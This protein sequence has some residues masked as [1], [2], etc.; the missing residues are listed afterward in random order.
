MQTCHPVHP[1]GS[2][3][4]ACTIANLRYICHVSSFSADTV[5]LI[6]IDN[7]PI[8]SFSSSKPPFSFWAARFLGV[9]PTHT[10]FPTSTFPPL[11]EL[12]VNTRTGWEKCKWVLFAEN[13]LAPCRGRSLFLSWIYICVTMTFL[14][15]VFVIFSLFHSFMTSKHGC[16]DVAFLIISL[17]P[18]FCKVYILKV[19]IHVFGSHSSLSVSIRHSRNGV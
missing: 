4:S 5:W 9:P 2:S 7:Q 17:S 10:H 14:W 15:G 16:H 13:S 1:L 8:T 6:T 3:S 11:D 18:S 12:H 19:L